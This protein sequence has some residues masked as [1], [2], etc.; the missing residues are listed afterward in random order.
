MMCLCDQPTELLWTL[1]ITQVDIERMLLECLGSF[2]SLVYL[3]RLI[4][5]E[6][7][8]CD[9]LILQKIFHRL[10]KLSTASKER[11]CWQHTHTQ[12][13]IAFS[14]EHK[15]RGR[16]CAALTCTH[17]TGVGSG[18]FERLSEMLAYDCSLCSFLCICA[19]A[20]IQRPQHPYEFVMHP[21]HG[22][23]WEI[24]GQTAR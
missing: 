2:C 8:L 12:A 13:V 21:S 19:C 9:W 7:M 23:H 22:S 18:V 14:Y 17:R 10:R 4:C 15:S 20:C 16:R 24:E 3:K 1:F 6:I 11:N 5:I